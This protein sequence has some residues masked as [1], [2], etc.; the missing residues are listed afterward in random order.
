MAAVRLTNDGETGLPPGILTIYERDKA[1][2]S[3]MSATAACR[4]SRSARSG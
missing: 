3:P 1:G 2:T 4:A